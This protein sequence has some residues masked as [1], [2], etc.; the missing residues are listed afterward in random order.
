MPSHGVLFSD[1]ITVVRNKPVSR[2]KGGCTSAGMILGIVATYTLQPILV[3]KII[4]H[5]VKIRRVNRPGHIHV[6]WCR[7]IALF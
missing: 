6:V 4:G 2:N 5:R 1:S 3:E 7:E